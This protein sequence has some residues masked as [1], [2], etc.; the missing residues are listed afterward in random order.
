MAEGRRKVF[1]SKKGWPL[2]GGEQEQ[3]GS[4]SL[5][6]VYVYTYILVGNYDLLSSFGTFLPYQACLGSQ[7]SV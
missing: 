4:S 5:L 2:A 1:V 3:L 7:R 6:P